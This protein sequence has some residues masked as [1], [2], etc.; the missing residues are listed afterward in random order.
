MNY[1]LIPGNPPATYFYELWRAE[2][3]AL[4]P[5]ARVRVSAYPLLSPRRDSPR[6]MEEVLAHHREGL[7][8]FHREALSPI[9]IIGHSLGAYFAMGLLA[10][11]PHFV[12]EAILVHPFLRAPSR[13]GRVILNSVGSLFDRPRFLKAIVRARRGLEWFSSDLRHV[14]DEEI[15]KSFQLARHESA[16]IAPDRT[17]LAIESGL[18]NKVRVFYSP[19]DTWCTKVVVAQFA[20]QVPVFEGAEPHGFITEERHRRSLFARI[21]Q[22]LS[23][24]PAK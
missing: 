14:T 11:R 6:A 19:G 21:T 5:E 8:E 7:E 2:I 16:T 4:V 12:E 10:S 18:R 13:L 15:L 20:N 9:T 17:A 23:T 22:T 1:F 3:S 24:S